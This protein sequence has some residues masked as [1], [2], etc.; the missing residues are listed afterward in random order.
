[1]TFFIPVSVVCT[2]VNLYECT[3]TVGLVV[4]QLMPS[5]P[6]YLIIKGKREQALRN[7][8]IVSRINCKPKLHIKLVT[9]QEKAEMNKQDSLSKKDLDDDHFNGGLPGASEIIFKWYCKILS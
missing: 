9:D 4:F 5:S 6:R 3:V 7:I 2:P 8:N 1:M